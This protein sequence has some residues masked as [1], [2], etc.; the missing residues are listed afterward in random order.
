[1]EN[2]KELAAAIIK[3]NQPENCKMYEGS[4]YAPQKQFE[5]SGIGYE[6]VALQYQNITRSIQKQLN[7]E[8]EAFND[9]LIYANR[10]LLYTSDAADE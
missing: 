1:M 5:M 3:I 4:H 2:S 10:C 8:S 7:G 6:H 9:D